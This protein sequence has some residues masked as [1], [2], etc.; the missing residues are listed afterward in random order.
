MWKD[1][2]TQEMN[3]MIIILLLK[4]SLSPIITSMKNHSAEQRS[5]Q[6]NTGVTL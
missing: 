4:Q 5:T 3:D 6:S 1:L 2:S